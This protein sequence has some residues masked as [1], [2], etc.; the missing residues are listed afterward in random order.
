MRSKI[1]VLLLAAGIV[2]LTFINAYAEPG[3]TKDQILIGNISA[4]SG[5]AS[6]VGD[7]IALA[8]RIAVEEINAAGGINGRK[9]K[10]VTEDDANDPG[11][12]FQVAK[13]LLDVDQVF[14]I[15]STSGSSNVLSIMRLV[16][17]QKVPVIVTTAPNKEIYKN[18]A[19]PTVF[20]IGADYSSEYYAQLKYIREK[21]VPAGTKTA[22]IRPDNLLG[23][24]INAGYVKAVKD[25]GFNHVE[26]IVFKQ[27]Q[28]DFNA[29]VMKMNSAGGKVL[30][31]GGIF[32]QTKSIM[33]EAR[34]LGM[35]GLIVTT[36]H[37]DSSPVTIKLV[38]EYNYPY[39]S[40]DYIA[41]RND[42][43][44]LAFLEKA[45]KYLNEEEL[46][47]VDHFV[48][49]TYIGF[50]TYFHA[51]KECGNNLTRER[52]VQ[53]LKEIKNLEIDGLIAPINFGNPQH[54]SGT[55]VKVYQFDP[56]K[57]QFKAVTG[58]QKF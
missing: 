32:G 1:S 7:S 27:G 18:G 53:K 43:A 49:A 42:A 34:R 6:A 31:C 41:N 48:I 26:D 15:N 25:F 58:F 56:A 20:T 13:K 51:M 57:R 3:I 40:A 17:Q 45:K 10:V 2:C 9:V 21:L 47:K 46:A 12:T 22:I 11:R 19:P 4:A 23:E 16:N 50:R 39:F 36:M 5:H 52:L 28:R 35:D 29:E 24:S 30:A 8:T 14:C 33:G 37:T 38:S 54:L 44:G 55:A